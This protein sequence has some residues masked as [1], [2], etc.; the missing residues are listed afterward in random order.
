MWTKREESTVPPH[1]RYTIV[2]TPTSS[3]GKL[4]DRLQYIILNSTSSNWSLPNI[5]AFRLRK[6]HKYCNS[7]PERLLIS[8]SSLEALQNRLKRNSR[9]PILFVCTVLY[10][11]PF[12]D[13]YCGVSISCTYNQ[14]C[15]WATV[16]PVWQNVLDSKTAAFRACEKK[17]KIEVTCYAWYIHTYIL[18]WIAPLRGSFVIPQQ[19]ATQAIKLWK[20]FFK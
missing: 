18:N 13:R 8:V 3:A 9:R 16:L 7:P 12:K 19:S 20:H 14:S 1:S 15:E 4:P 6:C 11:R 10:G 2:I 5:V 17:K